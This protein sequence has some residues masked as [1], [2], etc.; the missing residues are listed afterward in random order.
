M[1][2]HLAHMDGRPWTS[3]DELR[4]QS[5]DL[6]DLLAHTYPRHNA[7]TLTRTEELASDVARR[8]MQKW[9]S[10][11]DGSNLVDVLQAWIAANQGD[12]LLNPLPFD[13]P[14]E[15]LGPVCFARRT[16][17]DARW[18]HQPTYLQCDCDYGL[19]CQAAAAA[20]AA[21]ERE[22]RE[23]HVEQHRR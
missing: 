4:V 10:Y 15:E 2:E 16:A 18:S 9:L 20:A 23:R 6:P 22:E 8:G 12:E 1:D 5:S 19:E 17:S 11:D 13:D 3:R 14:E 7:H 21:Q